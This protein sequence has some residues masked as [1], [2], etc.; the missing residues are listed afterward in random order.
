MTAGSFFDRE[1]VRGNVATVVVPV[2]CGQCAVPIDLRPPTAPA[3]HSYTVATA[4]AGERFAR[5]E[6]PDAHSHTLKS[7]SPPW[8][9]SGADGV[10][11]DVTTNGPS[12]F[13]ETDHRYQE[14][15][16]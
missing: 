6:D 11:R 3:H 13:R 4:A 8:N 15:L 1:T 5:L 16:C 12:G 2:S 9:K 14:Y 10:L 7:L